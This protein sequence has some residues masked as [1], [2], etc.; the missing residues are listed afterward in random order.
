MP[1]QMSPWA[2]LQ[3][4]PLVRARWPLA[5]DKAALGQGSCWEWGLGVHLCL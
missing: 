1:E 3:P 4:G 2:L 5:S